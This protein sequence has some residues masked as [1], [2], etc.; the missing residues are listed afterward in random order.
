MPGLVNPNAASP[1]LLQALLRNVSAPTAVT[2]RSGLTDAI[3]G[4]R[5]PDAQSAEYGTTTPTVRPGLS[6]RAGAIALSK[7]R[8]NGAA[9]RHDAGGCS[10][11]ACAP[12]LSVY[13]ITAINPDPA[14]PIVRQA[15]RDAG[16][17]IGR[18]EF[19]D[20][21]STR[22]HHRRQGFGVQAGKS[23]R[24]S[25]IRLG[26]PGDAVP[27]KILTWQTGADGAIEH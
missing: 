24:R 27:F 18:C 11:A 22:C 12:H 7:S 16:E 25:A 5:T 2:A 3:V 10:I 9:A 20:T 14:D 1:A 26:R 21:I 19:D 23:V 4:W 6:V 8:R 15:L 13:N 17:A